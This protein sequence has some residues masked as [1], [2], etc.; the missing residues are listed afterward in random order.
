MPLPNPDIPTPP[1]W[2]QSLPRLITR[3]AVLVAIVYLSQLAIG[4]AL[5]WTESLPQ[6]EQ[7][8]AQFWVLAGVFTLYTLLISIPFVP[9]LEIALALLMLRGAELALPIY[10]STVLG[11]IL[12]YGAGH[13]IPLSALARVFLDLHLTRAAALTREMA[14]LPSRDRAAALQSHL[15]SRFA[16]PALRYRYLGLALLI[17]MP[18]SGLIG[19]GGGICLTAGMSRLFSP[20]WSM[21][22]LSLA[23]LPFPLLVWISGSTGISAWLP[24]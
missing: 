1:P 4:A 7:D 13:L 20:H 16:A 15:P 19:G 14:A 11:L 23:V 24:G 21:L 22:T 8:A 9:G 12:A 18:G 3:L 5:T 10:L 6:G 17:N 2:R